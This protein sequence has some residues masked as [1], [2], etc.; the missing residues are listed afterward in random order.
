MSTG[1]TQTFPDAKEEGCVCMNMRSESC[2]LLLKKMTYF[3]TPGLLWAVLDHCNETSIMA[4][5]GD[6][7]VVGVTK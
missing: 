3:C 1:Q 4:G 5:V 6:T 7:C 2:Y